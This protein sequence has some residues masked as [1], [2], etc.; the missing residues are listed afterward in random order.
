MI[1]KIGQWKTEV[2]SY[3]EKN[4]VYSKLTNENLHLFIVNLLIKPIDEAP[5]E[6]AFDDYKNG[7]IEIWETDYN[8]VGQKF[9]GTVIK[10][11]TNSMSE[12]KEY[13]IELQ[14][15][16]NK[17]ITEL[18]FESLVLK[19]YN[20][21]QE[22]S[23]EAIIIEAKVVL[24]KKDMDEINQLR[25]DMERQYFS[26]VRGGVSDE[27]IRM[28]FGRN[29]WSQNNGKY[30]MMM[31]LVEEIY[32]KKKDDLHGFCEPELGI[33]MRKIIELY[34][35]NNRLLSMLTENALISD[36]QKNKVLKAMD[37]MEINKGLYVF[38]CVKNI[39]EW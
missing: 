25:C 17:V 20:V 13:V 12:E 16:S 4:I 14:E 31:T 36:D 29:L 24:D 35:I 2:D 30:K 39:D 37:K 6:K 27:P 33:A 1:I 15:I 5:F 32:D 22:L 21:K 11:I 19:P 34:E 28:R 18:R 8:F 3:G 10:T 26:V 23:E 9:S 7:A 38:D